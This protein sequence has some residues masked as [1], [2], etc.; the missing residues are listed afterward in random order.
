MFEAIGEA[1]ES[2]FTIMIIIIIVAVPLAI[3]KTIEIIMW[4][5]QNL[6]ITVGE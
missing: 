2:F 5:C 3:W 1:I 6:T 4:I